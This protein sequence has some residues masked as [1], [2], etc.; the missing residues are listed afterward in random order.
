MLYAGGVYGPL[1]HLTA[2]VAR[3][4][5]F[6]DRSPSS[7]MFFLFVFVLFFV[8]REQ[9]R[10]NP[11]D[12]CTHFLNALYYYRCRLTTY[13]VLGI[14]YAY[15]CVTFTISEGF[16]ET[17]ESTVGE[18]HRQGFLRYSIDHLIEPAL[19]VKPS[20]SVWQKQR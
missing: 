16:Q 18:N 4:L 9:V 1:L 6:V 5:D 20:R 2:D 13:L 19:L 11:Q 12:N 8:G 3:L 15:P 7:L 17:M 10:G 14:I